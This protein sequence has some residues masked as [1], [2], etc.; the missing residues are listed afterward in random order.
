MGH[1]ISI[2]TDTNIHFIT[3]TN[4]KL[5][6]TF[7]NFGARWYNFHVP[8][9]NQLIENILLS[10]D[11]P[12]E[13]LADYA[14]FGALIGPVAGRI[15]EAKWNTLPLDAND[16]KHHVHGGSHGWANQFWD[17]TIEETKDKTKVS[18]SLTDTLSGYPG[19]I[20]V[21]NSYELTTSSVIMTTQV[22]SKEK[23]I[24]N[25]T[26]HAYFNLSGNAKRSINNHSL[27]INSTNRLELDSEHLPTGKITPLKNTAYDFK[28][29]TQLDSALLTLENGLNDPYLLNQTTEAQI[30]LSDSISG[31][32]LNIYSNRE[33]VIVFSTT[34][35]EAEFKV[36]N[37]QMTSELGI[38][39]ETQELPDIVN[40]PEW[41]NI[42][43]PA[44]KTK[45]YQTIYEIDFI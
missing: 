36:N 10:I 1:S 45:K 25:P 37:K 39:L 15:K 34:G 21:I 4:D 17:Y 22:T 26:N 24:A 14:Q 7:L 23:T 32:K 42:E 5:S 11:T 29:S 31:R 28:E 20:H 16:G 33:S 13:I 38:A 8:D 43:L 41:G 35:F 19:P 12:Q 30:I 2:N 44:G 9:K 6:A 40:H 18:F 3:L 27:K